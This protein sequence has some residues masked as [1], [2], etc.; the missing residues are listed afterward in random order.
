[1]LSTNSGYIPGFAEGIVGHTVGETF[2]V[3]VIFPSDYHQSSLAGKETVFTMTLNAIY[4]VRGAYLWMQV[5]EGTTV[6]SYPEESYRYFL[7]Q[8]QDTYHM[9]AYYYGM[10]YEVFLM[11]YGISEDAMVEA[12]KANAAN[13]LSVF[14]VIET[15]GLDITSEVNALT[16][17]MVTELMENNEMTREE[18]SKYVEENNLYQVRA[19][20]ACTTV[21]NWL[22][23]ENAAS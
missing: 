18:A 11:M 6:S 15:Y 19:Q 13:F 9:Y 5:S 7:Q 20:A 2:N 8:Y 22:L 16:E 1:M 23:Q 14:S 21:L 4:D 17:A 3:K 10:E 12:A